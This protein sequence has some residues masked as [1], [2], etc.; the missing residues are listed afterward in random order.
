MDKEKK[1]N[2]AN[3]EEE[4]ALIYPITEEGIFP[5]P[6]TIEQYELFLEELEKKMVN[7]KKD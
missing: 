7:H 1:V 2:Q 6:M 3:K 4:Q 5:F